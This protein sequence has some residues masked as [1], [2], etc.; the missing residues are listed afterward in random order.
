MFFLSTRLCICIFCFLFCCYFYNK[1]LFSCINVHGRSLRKIFDTFVYL[2]ICP[3][4]FVSSLRRHRPDPRDCPP[5]NTCFLL[6]LFFTYYRWYSY[7]PPPF[8][9]SVRLQIDYKLLCVYLYIYI[10]VHVYIFWSVS[11][12]SVRGATT[13]R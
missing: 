3:L 12:R 9:H 6:A 11:L 7:S 1:L 8:K 5:K 4:L 2:Y 13:Y 10:Y